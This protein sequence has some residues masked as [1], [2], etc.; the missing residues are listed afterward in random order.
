MRSHAMVRPLVDR[1]GSVRRRFFLNH[2]KRFL[3]PLLRDP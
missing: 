1:F 2:D 3:L